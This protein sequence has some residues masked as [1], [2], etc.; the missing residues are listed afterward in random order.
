MK[1]VLHHNKDLDLTYIVLDVRNNTRENVSCSR[2][3]FFNK[4]LLEI[5]SICVMIGDSIKLTFS[6]KQDEDIIP[7]AAFEYVVQAGGLMNKDQFS[8]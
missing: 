6:T 3:L 2:R 1:E 5:G 7:F 8:K 4:H